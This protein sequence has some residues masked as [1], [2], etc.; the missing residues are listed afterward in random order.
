MSCIGVTASE[1]E[2]QPSGEV[3]AHGCLLQCDQR[4]LVA[5]GAAVSF[6]E[7][8]YPPLRGSTRLL[9]DDPLRSFSWDSLERSEQILG[10]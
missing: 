4:S 5:V 1:R 6:A 9:H 2:H 8:L 7:R 10:Q 3:I